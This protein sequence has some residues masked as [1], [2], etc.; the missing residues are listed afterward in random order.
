MN[1]NIV[2]MEN[3]PNVFIDHITLLPKDNGGYFMKLTIAMYDSKNNPSWRDRIQ[4]LKIKISYEASELSIQKLNSGEE[5]LSNY[6]PITIQ[7]PTELVTRQTIVISA[8]ELGFMQDLGDYLKY[9][10]AVEF[11]TRK[12]ENLN[13]YAACFIED[14]GFDNDL[15]DKFYGPMSGERIMVGGQINSVTNYFYY[16]DTNEEYGGPVHQHPDGSFMEGSEHSGDN[17]KALRRVEE[18]NA[19]IHETSYI[20]SADEKIQ[21]GLPNY[22]FNAIDQSLGNAVSDAINNLGENNSPS[23][24]STDLTGT[25]T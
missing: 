7:N 19:K 20:F 12:Y 15:F 21:T 8:V 9:G 23:V 5:S 1:D 6:I 24:D 18:E 11:H 22:M 17:L 16:P 13:A 14:F 3:L 10:T 25:Y 4:D 2:G